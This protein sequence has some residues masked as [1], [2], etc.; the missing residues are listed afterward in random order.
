M[1][2]KKVY[3]DDDGRTIVDMNV[4]GMP[5]YSPFMIRR[6]WKKNKPVIAEDGS[7]IPASELEEFVP[8]EEQMSKKDLIR[9]ICSATLAALVV[10]LI[11]SAGLVLFTLFCTEI[12]F[13]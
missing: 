8:Q 6:K 4:E 7:E 2:K 11:L 12:W 5:Q 9:S 10:V 3:D 1:S 13:K